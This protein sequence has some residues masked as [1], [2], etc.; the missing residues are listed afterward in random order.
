MD[1]RLEGSLGWL[2][3]DYTTETTAIPE[4]IIAEEAAAG[5]LAVI[6]VSAIISI[7]LLFIIAIFI[8]CRHQKAKNGKLRSRMFK[9][10]LPKFA[11]PR[12]D[13]EPIADKME[14]EEATPAPATVIV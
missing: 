6:I 11:T 9:I 1:N 7:T 5:S 8:D 14:T 3:D 12:V 4:I 10:T 13:Q 2:K